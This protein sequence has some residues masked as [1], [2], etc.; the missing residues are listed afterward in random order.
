MRP[1]VHIDDVEAMRA[2]DVDH[3]DPLLFRYVQNFEFVGGGPETRTRS[4]LAARVG[5]V[6]QKVGVPIVQK[7]SGPWLE[8]DIIDVDWCCQ[9]RTRLVAARI[10][11]QSP[12]ASPYSFFTWRR[13]QV[14]S[15]VRPSW[16]RSSAGSGWR[17]LRERENHGDQ[18]KRTQNEYSSKRLK[19]STFHVGLH[20]RLPFPTPNMIRPDVIAGLR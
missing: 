2:A 8:W 3:I 11:R 14:Y 20:S 18:Q 12:A 17:S 6:L 19:K 10:D 15:P 16:C 1:A 9:R 4:R 7:N 13:I 5:L